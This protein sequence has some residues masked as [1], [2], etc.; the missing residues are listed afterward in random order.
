SSGS[1]ATSVG[2][3]LND[4]TLAGGTFWAVGDRPSAVT[5]KPRTLIDRWDGTRWVDLGGPNPGQLGPYDLY[6]LFSITRVPGTAHAMWALGR[7]ASGGQRLS[8]LLR[9]P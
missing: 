9:H 4:V 3:Q 5:G 2:H 8:F 6:Q 1:R 7:G